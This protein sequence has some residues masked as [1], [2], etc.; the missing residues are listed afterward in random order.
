MTIVV[1]WPSNTLCWFRHFLAIG[2]GLEEGGREQR[3][4][5]CTAVH[6]AH[7]V[8]A[9]PTPSH[10]LPSVPAMKGCWR[11]ARYAAAGGACAAA[12]AAT[13][14]KSPVAWCQSVAQSPAPFA[15]WDEYVMSAAGP[16]SR[17]WDQDWDGRH[18]KVRPPPPPAGQ[19][20]IRA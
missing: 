18:P 17:S 12:V 1:L 20:G 16:W 7:P 13:S 3:S 14:Q 2:G 11:L 9:S 8:S 19:P 10:A 15:T 5:H 6:R 4:G